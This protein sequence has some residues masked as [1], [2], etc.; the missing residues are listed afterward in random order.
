MGEDA[1]ANAHHDSYPSA[2]RTEKRGVYFR[3]RNVKDPVVATLQ[4]AQLGC[5]Q[6]ATQVDDN[7]KFSLV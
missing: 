6:H 2:S 3:A 5:R 7:R 4:Y 1:I